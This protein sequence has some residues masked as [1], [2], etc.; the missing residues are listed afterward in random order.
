MESSKI[1]VNI[2]NKE[3]IKKYKKI[4]IT[5][6]LFALEGFSVGYNTFSLEELK[7]LDINI[8]LNINSLMDTK[9]IDD[10]KKIIPSLSFVKG[11]FFEDLGVYYVLKDKDISLI[12]SQNHFVLNSKSINFWLNRVESACLANELTLDEI[13]YILSKSVK[14]LILNV[15]GYNMAMYSRRYILSNFNRYNHLKMVKKGILKVNDSNSFIAIENE[16]GRALFYNKPFNYLS[17]LKEIDDSKIKFYYF[18]NL[19]LKADEIIDIITKGKEIIS[20]EKF[21]NEK[22]IY[23]LE[24]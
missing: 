14:P 4:G 1:L 24:G 22:T 2:N 21:I 12:W 19:N 15:L 13:N 8:Y 10:F 9:M 3:D 6:F 18:S 20:E 16:N 5:N 17:H 23:K 7:E 11:I